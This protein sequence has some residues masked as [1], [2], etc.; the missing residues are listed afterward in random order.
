MPG[1]ARNR[2]GFSLIELMIVVAILGVLATLST[3]AFNGY[4]RRSKSAEA[5]SNLNLLFKAVATYYDKERTMSRGL[6]ATI[7][8]YC[9]LGP[10]TMTPWDPGGDKQRFTSPAALM[11]TGFDIA[12]YVYYSYGLTSEGAAC[13]NP[14]N[15]PTVYTLFAHG[16]LD[17]DN[18]N[19]TFELAVGSNGN[20]QLF[21]SRGFYIVDQIE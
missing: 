18:D 17:A 6:T 7:S 19:S 16:D 2:S 1:R 10:Q 5:T 9:V 13:G 12:D 14:A 21:H 3:A 20:N 8:G 4:A 15:D 11:E